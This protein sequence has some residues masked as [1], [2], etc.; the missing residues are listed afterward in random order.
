MK[1]VIGT[2]HSGQPTPNVDQTFGPDGLYR[3]LQES[4]YIVNALPATAETHAVLDRAAFAATRTGAVLV[5]IGRGATVDT[6]ALVSAL[7]AGKLAGA[8]LDVT[9]PEPLP[10]EHEL[11]QLPGVIITPH[12]A[13]AHPGYAER[14]TQIFVANLRRYLRGEPLLNLVDKRAGY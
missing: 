7:R 5:N 12:Y 6:D 14:V 2:R 3:V 11:W 8:L 13:G 9:A 4:D 10:K 1:C